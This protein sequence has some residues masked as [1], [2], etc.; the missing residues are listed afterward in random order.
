MS[1]LTIADLPDVCGICT[2]M[3]ERSPTEPHHCH[4][5]VRWQGVRETG[6]IVL[7]AKPCRCECRNGRTA[8][9]LHINAPEAAS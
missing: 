9:V 5:Y 7:L 6:D 8:S 4:G 1:Q 3:A 2:Y